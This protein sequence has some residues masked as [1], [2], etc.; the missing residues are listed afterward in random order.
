LPCIAPATLVGSEDGGTHPFEV[1]NFVAGNA[2]D[3][4]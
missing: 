2:G 1:A 3:G 4:L